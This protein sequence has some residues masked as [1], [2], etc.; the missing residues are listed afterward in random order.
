MQNNEL[1]DK[2]IRN[3][4]IGMSNN[5]LSNN[6]LIDIIETS[7]SY[8]NLMTISDYSKHNKISYNGAKHFRE[9]LELFG[10]KFIIDND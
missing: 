4:Y 10:V 2:I 3:I 5:M 7:G 6:D 1:K 8:L 9:Q